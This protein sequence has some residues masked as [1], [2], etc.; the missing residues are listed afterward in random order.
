MENSTTTNPQ[1]DV[2]LLE[3]S[4]CLNML[5]EPISIPCGHTFCRPCL[6]TAQQRSQKKCPICRAVCVVDASI[7]N[8]NIQLSAILKTCFPQQYTE[9]LKEISELKNN[10]KQTLP[11]FFYNEMLYPT[12]VLR[13][14]LFEPR[15]KLMI[16]RALEATRCFAYVPNFKDY[17]AKQGDIGLVARVE[18]C[19]FLFD[20]RAL[21]EANITIRFKITDHWVE[22]G[23]NNLFYCQYVELVDD[24]EK[25]EEI[26]PLYE[27]GLKNI[28]KFRNFIGSLDPIKQFTIKEV[29]GAFP[30]ATASPSV[31]CW[32]LI[33]TIS[34]IG[35][36]SDQLRYELLSST[37]LKCRLEKINAEADLIAFS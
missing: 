28:E 36:M 13:L 37:S 4:I 9:R 18:D 34:K 26:L 22:E 2:T 30:P 32:W 10:W 16:K 7:Q 1:L 6:V 14:H 31:I 15:Y 25:E 8:E 24:V 19:Q 5:A 27:K 35:G 3:C 17:K 33:K 21:L 20:G 12:S 29:L 11:I 23:T